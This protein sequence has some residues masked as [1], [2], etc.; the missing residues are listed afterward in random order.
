MKN[1]Y[2]YSDGS[3]LAYH[4]PYKDLYREGGPAVEESDGTKEWYLNDKL[5]REDGPAVEYPDGY[6]EWW[7]NGRCHR[8]G[9]PA[10]EY[11][12][13]S[14][15]WYVNGKCHRIGAPAVEESDGTKE[16][17][18]DGV[19]YSEENYWKEMNKINNMSNIM[20]LVDPRD[21]VRRYKKIQLSV[22]LIRKL[23]EDLN[24]F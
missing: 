14:T 22:K 11:A 21:W 16:W 7:L 15:I 4:D 10:I 13:G 6:R 17:Y 18:L 9:A 20:K 8:E 3:V 5:H 2:Y 23:S 24:E 1:R 12:D 19:E